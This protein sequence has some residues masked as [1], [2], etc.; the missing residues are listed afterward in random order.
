M[1]SAKCSLAILQRQVCR[2]RTG[3]T[4]SVLILVVVLLVLLALMGTAY[5]TTTRIDRFSAK[6][7]QSNTQ[8][9]LIVDGVRDMA[10]SRIANMPANFR[11]G[12]WLAARHPIAT[13]TPLPVSIAA[14][15]TISMPLTSPDFVS[16]SFN[17]PLSGAA[18]SGFAGNKD[19]L[20][21]QPTTMT[22]NGVVYPALQSLDNL[23]AAAGPVPFV[24]ADTDGDGI[25]D[26]GY[27]AVP[28]AEIDGI[29]YYAALRIV[30]NNSAINANTAW[31][32]ADFDRG[33]ALLAN[34]SQ[35]LFLS[36][37][38]MNEL[39]QSYPAVLPTTLGGQGT[40]SVK[41]NTRRWRGV[42][43][44]SG[45]VTGPDYPI[46]D[47]GAPRNEYKF[48]SQGD[49]QSSQLG[50]RIRNPGHVSA[51]ANYASY[52]IA[53]QF[54]LTYPF[55]IH[56]ALGS[57][58][59]LEQDLD[60]TLVTTA[61]QAAYAGNDAAMW[62]HDNFNWAD[63][64]YP[65]PASPL[66]P[67]PAAAI[68]SYF[69]AQNARSNAVTPPAGGPPLAGMPAWEAH[70][71]KADANTSDF[72]TLWRAYWAVMTDP[73]NS[74]LPRQPAAAMFAANTLMRTRGVPVTSP[75][76]PQNEVV[77][78]RAALAAANTIALREGDDG[79]PPPLPPPPLISNDMVPSF[80]VPLNAANS[81]YAVVYGLKRQPFISECAVVRVIDATGVPTDPSIAIE[82]YNPT[83]VAIDLANY[84]VGV[85]D[86]SAPNP[87]IT[88]VYPLSGSIPADGMLV[89]HDFT[90]VI[91]PEFG[92]TAG[93]R[94]TGMAAAVG[95][96]LVV[97]RTRGTL[98]ATG[99]MIPA[100]A[101]FNA[102]NE[103]NA[104]DRV[105]V[106]QVDVRALPAGIANTRQT[107]VYA[108]PS[109]DV[110]DWRCVFGGDYPAAGTGH[111]F[112]AGTAGLGAKQ[113]TNT[114]VL[115]APFDAPPAAPVI[116]INAFGHVGPNPWQGAPTPKAFP[117]GGFARNGD[118]L[119]VPF[120]GS[121]KIVDVDLATG[122]PT[123]V[124]INS[125]TL[126]AVRAVDAN[127]GAGQQVGRF[128]PT[129][130]PAPA[131]D[132]YAWTNHL[133]NYVTVQSPQ[134][135]Y[136]PNVTPSPV[137]TYPPAA[138]IAYLPVPQR[139]PNGPIM[140]PAQANQGN[141]WMTG[142]NGLININTASWK[143]LSMLPLVIDGTTGQVD[144]AATDT[145]AKAIIADRNTYGPF[146]SIMDLNRIPTF[147]S[148]P[149]GF[150]YDQRR[151]ELMPVTGGN[152]VFRRDSLQFTRLSNL[153]T[154]GSDTFTV[155]MVVEGWRNAGT[156]RATKEVEARRCYIF[157]R[158][159]ATT[160]NPLTITPVPTR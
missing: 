35:G 23:G 155:Y 33:G 51:A 80:C 100:V 38:G 39:L 10:K 44:Q 104:A 149:P 9:D 3:R 81:R 82:L 115:P 62:F 117:F 90:T 107:C 105:P 122:V 121:Y 106:D 120:I 140:N 41:L 21:F 11:T 18:V 34:P 144:R 30:D 125:V 116:E 7:H 128:W 136:L 135:D 114:P 98:V 63:M 126:D 52:D 108:R 151:G 158:N 152:A 127:A 28:G 141:E 22:I 113:D 58:A 102:F 72:Q 150:A 74:T 16:T 45:I 84:S 124:E 133:F 110:N 31:A 55:A 87:V 132:P 73:A 119:Q 29:K 75:L 43:V 130:L 37:V 2:P 77:A 57:A 139:V 148:P 1:K 67:R 137:T 50:R 92:A 61:R 118:I 79:T 15:P 32:L 111:V 96:E 27:F 25:A 131:S 64:G 95:Q 14:W 93:T 60:A 123:M 134:D 69:V 138:A 88:A 8:I 70:P 157:D 78:L 103:A 143:V 112:L 65:A 76:M 101:P 53:Q 59:S 42:P 12:T 145:L 5:L 20:Y 109:S 49:A 71:A 129:R 156:A 24:A 153:I 47:A 13:G 4:G 54:S 6:Q 146:T 99:T 142:V 46:D 154:A 86:R 17:N 40:E 68:R 160:Q 66:D 26:A 83:T 97:L 147:P 91:P 85:V 56:P 89:F 159:R 48:V 36:S 19:S 94:I